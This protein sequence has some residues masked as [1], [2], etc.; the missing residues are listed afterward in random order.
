[1]FKVTIL[2]QTLKNWRLYAMILAA[3]CSGQKG[4]ADESLFLDRGHKVF[5]EPSQN[6]ARLSELNA[7]GLVGTPTNDVEQVRAHLVKGLPVLLN[8]PMYR[9]EQSIYPVGHDAPALSNLKIGGLGTNPGKYYGYHATLAVGYIPGSTIGQGKL[10]IVD[11]D[12]GGLYLLDES[13][14]ASVTQN[15]MGQRTI[16]VDVKSP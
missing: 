5:R 12:P 8:I 10:L 11:S 16:L 7:A 1:M 15:Q 14:L 4:R 13:D 2:V 9:K 6:D 3:L